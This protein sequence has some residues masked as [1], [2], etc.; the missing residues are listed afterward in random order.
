MKLFKAMQ[1]FHLRYLRTQR[2]SGKKN[3]VVILK[4]TCFQHICR[5]FRKV[6]VKGFLDDMSGTQ[7]EEMLCDSFKKHPFSIKVRRGSQSQKTKREREKH[8]H[9]LCC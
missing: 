8:S 2:S 1:K 9:E 4:Q 6:V 5:R 7:T 3:D